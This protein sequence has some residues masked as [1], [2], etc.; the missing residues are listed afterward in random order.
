M[1]F[2]LPEPAP[3][4]SQTA[5]LSLSPDNAYLF[6]GYTIG[7]NPAG[8]SRRQT[9]VVLPEGFAAIGMSGDPSLAQRDNCG[10]SVAAGGTCTITVTFQ[11]VAYATF[12]SI[13]LNP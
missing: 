3:G 11:P 2:R 7:D 12:T 1:P 10:A 9:P 8:R 6:S 13:L 5:A 4:N